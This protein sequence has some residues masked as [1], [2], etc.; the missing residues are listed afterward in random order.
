MQFIDAFQK[1]RMYALRSAVIVQPELTHEW[2]PKAPTTAPLQM[3]IFVWDIIF[4]K[5]FYDKILN[6]FI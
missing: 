1:S 3:G 5:S 2:S 6:A 4:V